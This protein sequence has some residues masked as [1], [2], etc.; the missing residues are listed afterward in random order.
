M[1]DRLERAR[2][3][4]GVLAFVEK[5]SAVHGVHMFTN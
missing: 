1:R 5:G 4:F 3:N 2:R